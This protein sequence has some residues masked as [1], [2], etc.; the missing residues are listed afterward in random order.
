MDERL[1][2]LK[3]IKMKCLDC[4]CGDKAEVKMCNSPTCPLYTFRTG[5]DTVRSS[6]AKVT[7]EDI[8]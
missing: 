6:L 2:P 5:K 4:C 3:A 8:E 7:S 1:T